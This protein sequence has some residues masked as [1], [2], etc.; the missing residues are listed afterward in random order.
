MF[1]TLLSPGCYE[2]ASGM[3]S[4]KVAFCFRLPSGKRC[5]LKIFVKCLVNGESKH[6]GEWQYRL[7]GLKSMI[8]PQCGFRIPSVLLPDRHWYFLEIWKPSWGWDNHEMIKVRKS[9]RDAFRN[10]PDLLPVAFR[11]A[12]FLKRSKS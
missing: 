6:S 12:V 5:F 3:P 1:K 9:F 4:G 11:D 2:W 7:R 8:Y 10:P